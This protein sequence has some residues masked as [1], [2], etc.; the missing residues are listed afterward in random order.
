MRRPTC[1]DAVI[2]FALGALLCAKPLGAESFA[3]AADRARRAER[4]HDAAQAIQGWSDALRLWKP[5]D[6]KK[7]RSEAFVARAAL[8]DEKGQWKEAALDFAEALKL[9]PKNA[10]LFHRRGLLFLRH[11][12]PSEALSDFY[13]AAQI[14]PDFP[15]N[16]FDRARAYD[17][18]GDSQFA[19]EDY[20]TACRLGLKK[21]CGPAKGLPLEP[22]PKKKPVNFNACIA[23]LSACV[24]K[25]ESFG[26]CVE[27][28]E[29]CDSASKKGCCPRAC[30]TLFK[31]L[32]GKTSE[33]QAFRK[34][35]GPG[36]PC[37]P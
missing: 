16:F 3:S 29:P 23:R 1:R 37:R 14:K 28:A 12:H 5:A 4:R 32:A 35:F 24:D 21:A 2:A 7:K 36:S 20:R 27:K 25:G 9:E 10:A 11:S 6:G 22:R 30:V 33:A 17:L 8:R 34:V 19:R 18:Q 13:K 15:E 31:N 26:S